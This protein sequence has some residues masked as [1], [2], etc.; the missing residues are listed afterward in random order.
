MAKRRAR[1][2]RGK[3]GLGVDPEPALTALASVDP[4]LGELIAEVGALRLG[5][6]RSRSVFASLTSAIVHQQLNGVAAASILAR[7]EA[8]APPR[9]VLSPED[10][11]SASDATLRA[12]GLSRSKIAALRDLAAKTVDGTVPG[13]AALERMDDEAIVDRL[14]QVRGVGRW[15]VEMLLI[16]RMGRPDVL[17]VDDYGIRKAVA[18]V[19]GLRALPAPAEVLARGER[20]RP[21]RSIASWYLW[22]A[23]E[24]PR[25]ERAASESRTKRDGVAG[26]APIRRRS[27]ARGAAGG[28]RP[29]AAGSREPRG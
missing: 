23:L 3:H 16:F 14:T 18:R 1:L 12:A 10:V 9:R 19:F 21:Y 28:K 2:F 8:L 6:D 27:K 13:W 7:V 15:T 17:P 24:L 11:T 25:V 29:G 26:P 22:R 4:L 5:R 20:W